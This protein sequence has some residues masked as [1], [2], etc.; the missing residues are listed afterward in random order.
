ME[1]QKCHKA[2]P[3]ACGVNTLSIECSIR[4]MVN[5]SERCHVS[6]P[7][8][9]LS[10][11]FASTVSGPLHFPIQVGKYINLFKKKKNTFGILTKI[12]IF[13]TIILR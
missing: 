2:H 1:G 8:H 13:Y 4:V 3:A 11:S 6:V 9:T 10:L 12:F 7:T 5:M